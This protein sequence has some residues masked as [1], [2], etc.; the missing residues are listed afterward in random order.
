M[1][2]LPKK[3]IVID[4]DEDEVIIKNNVEDN[5]NAN[6]SKEKKNESTPIKS[7]NT[8]NQKELSANKIE[9][10]QKSENNSTN[11]KQQSSMK[12]SSPIKKTNINPTVK[13]QIS[14]ITNSNKSQ[15]NQSQIKDDKYLNKKTN[16]PKDIKDNTNKKDNIKKRKSSS[17]SSDEDSYS[18][19][20]SSYS[21]SYYSGSSSSSGSYSSSSSYSKSSSPKKVKTEHKKEIPKKVKQ[22]KEII[23]KHDYSINKHKKENI[24]K[25]S[26]NLDKKSELV[27]DILIRWWYALPKWPPENYD[28]SA[29]LKENKLRLV[30]LSDWKKEPNKNEEGLCKCFEM[31]G[32]K[33]VYMD[34]F[35]KTIDLRPEEGKPSYNSLIKE[36]EGKLYKLL[37]TAL[38]KQIEELQNLQNKSRNDNL[39]ISK[40]ES[41]LKKVEAKI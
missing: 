34:P 36:N 21:S 29:K 27:N 30:S 12:I 20:S 28:T 1:T 13:P 18:S 25:K 33:Y 26:K 37:S 4:D 24:I 14:K 40:L 16:R 23:K 8:I 31:P 10:K 35:G 9:S 19:S 11:Q 22:N 5:K 3:Y 39:L 6:I 38:K 32:F 7:N 15:Q 2:S 17:Y 41:K